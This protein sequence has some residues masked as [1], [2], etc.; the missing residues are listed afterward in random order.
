MC[1]NHKFIVFALY[2]ISGR[3]SEVLCED[4]QKNFT[5][6]NTQT[7]PSNNNHFQ[8]VRKTCCS[9]HSSQPRE[10][11]PSDQL[12]VKESITSEKIKKNLPSQGDCCK[13]HESKD[14]AV[15]NPEA[16]NKNNRITI[17]KSFCS[18][19]EVCNCDCKKQDSNDVTSCRCGCK[20]G[21]TCG[22]PCSQKTQLNSSSNKFNCS[23]KNGCKPGCKCGC[24]CFKN[25]LEAPKPRCNCPCKNSC[26]YQH[27][28]CS[29][30]CKINC[31]CGCVCSLGKH[32]TNT[33][34]F[35]SS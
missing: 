17:E 16:N 2:I 9:H 6:K 3:N 31:P 10:F 7:L 8:E 25:I 14:D 29:C 1:L 15:S 32:D 21:C 12:K 13:F 35:H 24:S 11:I 19:S 28:N 20:L 4:H 23:C 33:N 5:E 27:Q 22:C 30:G 18:N 26:S 34:C